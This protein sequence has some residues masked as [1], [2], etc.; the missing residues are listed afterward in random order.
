LHCSAL[1]VAHLKS[2]RSGLRFGGLLFPLKKIFSASAYGYQHPAQHKEAPFSLLSLRAAW[3]KRCV[4]L[5]TPLKA[6]HAK[7][8]S[9]TKKL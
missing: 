7:A 9:A 3:L 2:A 6:L 8:S 1:A 5:P 4:S